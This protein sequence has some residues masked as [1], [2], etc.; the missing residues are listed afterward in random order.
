MKRG[1]LPEAGRR[2]AVPGGKHQHECARSRLWGRL[3]R[4]VG[5]LSL[6]SAPSAWR[7]R[8][9]PLAVV[10]GEARCDLDSLRHGHDRA[11]SSTGMKH[12]GT[13]AAQANARCSLVA[14]GLGHRRKEPPFDQPAR[15]RIDRPGGPRSPRSAD[16]SFLLATTMCRFF[17]I[18]LF[19]GADTG[20]LALTWSKTAPVVSFRVSRAAPRSGRSPT[21]SMAPRLG[22]EI[23]LS[24]DDPWAID[25]EVA[26]TPRLRRGATLRS[27]VWRTISAG[28]MERHER[29][30]DRRRRPPPSRG[31]KC[32]GGGR[33]PRSRLCLQRSARAMVRASWRPFTTAAVVEQI[34]EGLLDLYFL[35]TDEVQALGP[36]AGVHARCRLERLLP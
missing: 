21:R 26:A 7:S 33:R 34:V 14:R 31:P 35:V 22:D 18:S 16:V 20:P 30:R 1:A 3:A 28:R 8:P 6:R 24:F 32:H 19:W 15:V 23:E 2:S 4:R 27:C 5:D 12:C 36:I 10:D 25:G 9:A 11:V 29:D 17:G 13:A